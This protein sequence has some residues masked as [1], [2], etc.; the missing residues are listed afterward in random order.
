M[1]TTAFVVYGESAP[2][3]SLLGMGVTPEGH[4]LRVRAQLH[5]QGARIILQRGAGDVRILEFQDRYVALRL[6]YQL[7]GFQNEVLFDD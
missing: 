4:T 3:N 5:G 2:P 7:C 6:A 1:T